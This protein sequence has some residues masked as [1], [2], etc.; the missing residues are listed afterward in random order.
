MTTINAT[1]GNKKVTISKGQN[2]YGDIVYRATL[3]QDYY[4]G[5]ETIERFIEMKTYSTEKKANN[6]AKKQLS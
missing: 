4:N 2:G 1:I 3:L 6:W 5:S